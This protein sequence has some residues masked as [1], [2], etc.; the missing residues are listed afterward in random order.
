MSFFIEA[1]R[2]KEAE[3][4]ASKLNSLE[5]RFSGAKQLVDQLTITRRKITKSIED[6]DGL[7]NDVDLADFD[8][9]N[10]KLLLGAL[11]LLKNALEGTDT[12]KGRVQVT[13]DGQLI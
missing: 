13:L 6:K 2:A 9:R 10:E 7:F 11:A 12:F 5:D 8:S 4:A 1:Q 3:S